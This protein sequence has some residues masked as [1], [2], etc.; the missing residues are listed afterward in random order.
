MHRPARPPTATVDKSDLLFPL[1]S[2][3]SPSLSLRDLRGLPSR[4]SRVK[5]FSFPALP[6]MAEAAEKQPPIPSRSSIWPQREMLESPN[7]ETS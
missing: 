3:F 2:F 1:R 4:P 7:L 5:S 6:K